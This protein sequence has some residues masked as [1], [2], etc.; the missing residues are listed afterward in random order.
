MPSAMAMASGLLAAAWKTCSERLRFG[1]VMSGNGLRYAMA[2][3]IIGEALSRTNQRKSAPRP[4]HPEQRHRR[5]RDIRVGAELRAGRGAAE[6]Q[7]ERG[8]GDR[9]MTGAEDECPHHPHHAAMLEPA[10]RR[11]V[12]GLH[13]RAP[14]N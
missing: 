13:R 2:A 6:E 1:T 9:Q 8:E 7:S 10:R 14:R 3:R 12:A 11:Q 5:P 4:R